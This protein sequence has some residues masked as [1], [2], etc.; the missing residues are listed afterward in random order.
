M[1]SCAI[2]CAYE[3]TEDDRSRPPRIP[4][5]RASRYQRIDDH[6]RSGRHCPVCVRRELVCPEHPVLSSRA[7]GRL[8]IRNL[9]WGLPWPMANSRRAWPHRRRPSLVANGAPRLGG[10]V[11]IHRLLACHVSLCSLHCPIQ[12]MAE[13]ASGWRRHFP[14]HSA[15]DWS[16]RIWSDDIST[17]V[18]GC[19]YIARN[20]FRGLDHF[21]TPG[22]IGYEANPPLLRMFSSAAARCISTTLR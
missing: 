22:S 5:P 15:R 17:R 14:L 16:R 10:I 9:L 12:G 4:S 11:Q 18:D 3:R 6:L 19:R 1:R 8:I 20:C 21:L 2:Y 7:N 13:G